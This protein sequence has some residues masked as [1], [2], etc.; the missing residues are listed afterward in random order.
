MT[1]MKMQTYL[2]EFSPGYLSILIFQ[3]QRLKQQLK[4]A[5][6]RFKGF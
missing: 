5:F 1:F 6:L 2:P 3:G 4:Y